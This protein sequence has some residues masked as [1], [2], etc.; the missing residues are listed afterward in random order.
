MIY[1]GDCLRAVGLVLKVLEQCV[2]D[3]V[4]GN[5]AGVNR[6]PVVDSS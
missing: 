5:W 4:V 1:N 2:A 3:Q 6:L